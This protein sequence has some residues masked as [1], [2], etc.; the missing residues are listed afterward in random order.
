MFHY[1]KMTLLHFDWHEVVGYVIICIII[2]TFTGL[3]SVW[4]RYRPLLKWYTDLEKLDENG[5]DY[6]KFINFFGTLTGSSSKYV[7]NIC[8]LFTKPHARM[9]L[10]QSWFIN[11]VLLPFQTYIDPT[12]GTG[13]GVF[14]PRSLCVSIK[15]YPNTGDNIFDNWYDFNKDKYD[16]GKYLTYSSDDT[17][18]WVDG[19]QGVYPRTT[20][21]DSWGK[22]IL[23][24]LNYGSDIKWKLSTVKSG[25]STMNAF[26]PAVDGETPT[27]HGWYYGYDGGINPT[28]FFA[29]YNIGPN[30][31]LIIY[32]INN[33]YS[34]GGLEVDPIAFQN[35]LGTDIEN[36]GQ[37]HRNTAGG[38]VGYLKGMGDDSS[39]DHY[40]SYIRSTVD[41]QVIVLPPGCNSSDISPQV[42]AAIIGGATWISMASG[43]Y[44]SWSHAAKAAALAGEKSPNPYIAIIGV[45]AFVLAAVLGAA[46]SYQTANPCYYG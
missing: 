7:Y 20:D 42:L 43:P 32:C 27:L 16:I 39:Y 40:L 23:S 18:D 6:S 30:S 17:P 19:K 12:T 14:T 41:M 26:V 28:N 45:G 10:S 2:Y 38:W 44:E 31:P 24:W 13:S 11:G 46:E 22:L 25:T 29:R 8:N 15:P 4:M 34:S 36:R 21:F 33:K 1:N 37:L 35:L 9:T 5:L 3:F